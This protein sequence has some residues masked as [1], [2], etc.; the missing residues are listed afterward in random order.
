M[1]SM[2]DWFLLTSYAK[3]TREDDAVNKALEQAAL[4]ATARL[5]RHDPVLPDITMREGQKQFAATSETG[6]GVNGA[7]EHLMTEADIVAPPS[8]VEAGDRTVDPNQVKYG[9]DF[10]F[11]PFIAVLLT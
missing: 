5:A 4:D 1:F 6:T 8:G 10:L 9:R 11:V 3:E 2:M 7:K